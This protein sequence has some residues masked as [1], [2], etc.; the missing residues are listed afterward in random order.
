[1]FIQNFLSSFLVSHL[2]SIWWF[3]S[4]LILSYF[5]AS[6]LLKSCVKKESLKQNLEFLKW[7]GLIFIANYL[8]KFFIDS[9]HIY[10]KYLFGL[11]LFLI[12][13]LFNS[14]LNGLFVNIYLNKIKKQKVNHIFIDLTKLIAFGVLFI[15]FLKE[16]I[17]ID[18]GSILTSSAILTGVIGLSMQDTIG[19]LISGLLIQIEKPFSLG[20]WIK[21]KEFEGRVVEI[22][23]RYTKIQTISFDYILIPNNSISRDTLINY[24]RPLPKIFRAVE[25]GV[26]LNIPPVKV[27]RSILEVLNTVSGIANNPKPRIAILRYENFRIIYRIGY[28]IYNL[29]QYRQIQDEV[30]TSI[31]YQF[32][33]HNIE[34]SLPKYIFFR[35]KEKITDYSEIE[36]LIASSILF[37]NL[38]KQALKLLIES[39]YIKTFNPKDFIIKKGEKDTEMYFII[40]GRV[41]VKDKTTTLSILKQGD[42]FGE[43]SLLTGQP[44][45]ADV[46]ALDKVEC[47]IVDREG[48]RMILSQN[49]Q[50]LENI[51]E[52]FEQRQ[53]S[54]QE[55]KFSETNKEN[56][57]KKFKNIFH[58]L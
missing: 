16:V 2:K 18:P 39:S 47:L 26:D 48:F 44:R 17:N 8:D 54:F 46:I 56:L 10:S 50:L 43:M 14:F 24:S 53:K 20:D 33:R 30:L 25:I 4:F 29:E 32:K 11:N 58:L 38:S 41:E 42:F 13:M 55:N 21:V 40:K 36:N 5:L 19:S 57:W 3:L 35:G 22:S 52:I 1:M 31:W 6:F 51:Q 37:K 28:Y 34:V 45:S 9:K 27:K 49:K 7:L 15:I 12:W 23:W